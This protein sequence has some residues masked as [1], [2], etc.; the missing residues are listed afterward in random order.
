[1]SYQALGSFWFLGMSILT[2][3]L[4]AVGGLLLVR[5]KFDHEMLS[6]HHDVAG[7]FMAVIGTL[8]AVVLGFIV[9]DSINSFQS[10]KANVEQESNALH[11]LFRVSQGLDAAVHRGIRQQCFYYAQIMVS[12][13]WPAMQNG[14]G[15]P[16]SHGIIDHLWWEIVHF[17]PKTAAQQ[18][19]HSAMIGD[20]ERLND[21]RHTRMVEANPNGNA[22]VW[23]SMIVGGFIVIVFSYF[24]GVR[25]IKVQALMT[26][27]LTLVLGL[28][29]A[30]VESFSTPFAGDIRVPPEPFELNIANF[31]KELAESSSATELTLQARDKHH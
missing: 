15:A 13:E 4:L 11:D 20:I 28:S 31:S 16:E 3:I 7:A 18:N 5:R 22:A 29:L 1:M 17:E 2:G 9:V 14:Q 25:N 8:Y 30:L 27:L 21:A 23:I 10:A 26:A 6:G 12:K 24:F 19:L